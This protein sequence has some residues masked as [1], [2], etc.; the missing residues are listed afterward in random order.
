MT[1]AD[2]DEGVKLLTSLAD[3]VQKELKE[4]NTLSAE[5]GEVNGSSCFFFIT[6]F[7]EMCR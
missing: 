7:F 6:Y 4:L 1:S 5:T 3:E 2:S